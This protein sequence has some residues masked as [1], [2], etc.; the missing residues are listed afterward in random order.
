MQL[1]RIRPI[2]R[3]IVREPSISVSMRSIESTRTRDEGITY[4]IRGPRRAGPRVRSEKQNAAAAFAEGSAFLAGS[5]LARPVEAVA[6]QGS[7]H[8]MGMATLLQRTIPNAEDESCASTQS[9][10][11]FRNC[12]AGNSRGGNGEVRIRVQA[13]GVC[14]SDVVT[15]EGLFPGI[16][17]PRVPG[18]EVVGTIDQLGVGVNGWNMGE[19]VG[20]GWYGGQDGTC[21]AAG[22]GIS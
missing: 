21:P 10:G 19:R 11:R 12:R 17:Y 14:H 13:C 9:R 5:C 3:R 15:K 18:H 6:N 7:L 4:A 2:K 8:V 22:E 20:V 16:V 1:E